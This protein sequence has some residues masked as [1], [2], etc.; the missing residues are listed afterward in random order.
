MIVPPVLLKIVLDIRTGGMGR[1]MEG[2]RGSKNGDV[3]PLAGG[4]QSYSVRSHIGT[5]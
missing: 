2:G 3:G 5:S 4:R 1:N